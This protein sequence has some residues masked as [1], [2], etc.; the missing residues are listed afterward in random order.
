VIAN[1]N[2]PSSAIA[3]SPEDQSLESKFSLVNKPLKVRFDRTNDFHQELK[4]RV[5]NYFTTTGRSPKD[6]PRMYLKSLVIFSWFLASWALLVF[7]A[8][9]WWQAI[10]LSLSLGMAMAGIG[11]S[12]QHDGNHKSYSDNSLINQ[13]GGFGADILGVSSYLWKQQH[14]LLHH[15]YTN[16]WGVD[17]DINLG[18]LSRLAPQQERY[19]FHRFQHIYL[20]I[21]YTLL[22]VAWHFYRDFKDLILGSIGEYKI[23][24]PKGKDLVVL[25]VGKIT[26][27]TM[28]FVIPCYFHPAWQVILAYLGASAVAGV[29][30]S[31]VFQTAHCMPQAQFVSLPDDSQ[32]LANNWAVHQLET[33]VDFAPNNALLTWYIGGLNYQVEHHLFP[34]ISHVHY[35]AIAPIVEAT[36][37]EY[38]VV[39]NVLPSFTSAI[40]SHIHWLWLMG[41]ETQETDRIV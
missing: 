10:I 37:K 17:H 18:D 4:Q 32:P 39:Y 41:Q 1:T 35:P 28:A 5:D 19:W 16:V 13:I 25:V 12:I 26:F 30:L 14:N 24:R 23:P 31:F 33:T 3:D 29:W 20:P 8:Q 6:S 40:G 38:G 9:T 22:V 7:A 36:C 2:P 11:L 15:S 27:F 21:L 34:G